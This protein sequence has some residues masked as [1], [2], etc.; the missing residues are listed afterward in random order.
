M[1]L[2]FVAKGFEVVLLDSQHCRA[3]SFIGTTHQ[4]TEWKRH[5]VYDELSKDCIVL[6]GMDLLQS[7]IRRLTARLLCSMSTSAWHLPFCLLLKAA[8]LPF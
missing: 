7:G 4:S 2:H 5:T 6:Y 3:V 8:M 1:A